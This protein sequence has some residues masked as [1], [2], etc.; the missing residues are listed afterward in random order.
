MRDTILSFLNIVLF[1]FLVC[2][3]L[4]VYTD[5]EVDRNLPDGIY[6]NISK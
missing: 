2:V 1:I 5:K 6:L 4:G 3:S